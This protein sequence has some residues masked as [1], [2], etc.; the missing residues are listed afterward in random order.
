MK[1]VV[2]TLY[3]LGGVHPTWFKINCYELEEIKKHLNLISKVNS[4]SF[5]LY[6]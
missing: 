1:V 4:A 6:K 2:K 5:K 3:K